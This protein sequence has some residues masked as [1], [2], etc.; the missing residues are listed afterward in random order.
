MRALS[1]A[2]ACCCLG[3]ASGFVG[4][5]MH[6]LRPLVS[7]S[8]NAFCNRVGPRP[9]VASRVSG[10]GFRHSAVS[11]LRAQLRKDDEPREADEAFPTVDVVDGPSMWPLFMLPVLPWPDLLT[12]HFLLK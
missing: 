8:A 9:A 5:A 12:C 11:A 1:L 3:V 4:P 6:R 10:H 2:L 7:P